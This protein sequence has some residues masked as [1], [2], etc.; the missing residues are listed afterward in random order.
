[1]LPNPRRRRR[2]S[3]ETL[4]RSWPWHCYWAWCCRFAGVLL[5]LGFVCPRALAIS[6]YQAVQIAE[7]D[8]KQLSKEQQ[9]FARYLWFPE[10]SD[11]TQVATAMMVNHAMSHAA[12]PITSL[13]TN[14]GI[15]GVWFLQGGVYR[16]DL[17]E[18][19]AG[20]VSWVMS[21]WETLIEREPYFTYRT[22]VAKTDKVEA[23]WDYSTPPY[24]PTLDNLKALT[25]SKVPIVNGAWLMSKSMQQ[26]NGGRYYIFRRLVPRRLNKDDKELTPIKVNDYLAKVGVNLHSI[27]NN[28]GIDRAVVYP[29]HPTESP[30]SIVLTTSNTIPPS[31]GTALVGIT[32]D[33]F[34]DD[35]GNPEF[36][37]E[38]NL[39][40]HKFRGQEII[41]TQPNGFPEYTLWD[42]NGNLVDEAPQKLAADRTIAHGL[43]RLNAPLSCIRCHGMER[44]WLK[45]DCRIRDRVASGQKITGDFS[46]E[47]VSDPGTLAQIKALYSGNL[48]TALFGG[49]ST[50]AHA[51]FLATAGPSGLHSVAEASAWTADVFSDYVYEEVDAHKAAA[52]L[53]LETIE[54]LPKVPEDDVKLL[55]IGQFPM[56]RKDWEFVYAR[57]A[58]R[59]ATLWKAL[60]TTPTQEVRPQ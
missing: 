18:I 6:P 27:E 17:A 26:I 28:V 8:L 60:P 36:D 45:I 55:D 52:E 10:Y 25:E 59:A 13:P 16:I 9:H 49:Q 40:G 56:K 38:R 48:N 35:Q 47:E 53:G 44:G 50:Y 23:H 43:P 3:R 41:V 29:R 24:L 12:Y 20:E 15:I 58:L 4:A 57:A 22:Q 37:P 1:M 34:E 11:K 51:V 32:F 31:R 54:Q 2:K 46:K 7:Y 30:G 5:L 19:G 14:S 21:L 42:A 33:I 39:L